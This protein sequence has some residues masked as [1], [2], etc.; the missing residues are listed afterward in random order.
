[1]NSKE[2]FKR[3]AH[4]IGSF[5]LMIIG[6]A[7]AVRAFSYGLGTFEEPGPGFMPFLAGIMMAFF[8]AIVL[9]I[10]LKRGWMPLR[11][12]WEGTKW[13]RAG[14]VIALLALFCIFLPY[15]GFIL[16]SFLIMIIL[17]R[18]VDKPKWVPTILFSLLT[19]TG[20]YLLFQV[21]LKSQLPIG[22]FGF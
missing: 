6:L 21:W 16:T 9:I 22:F 13:W 2:S 7:F 14:I 4:P 1:M 15:L 10:N 17:F 20:F 12:L 19:T 5:W 8:C 18:L 11:T 3:D